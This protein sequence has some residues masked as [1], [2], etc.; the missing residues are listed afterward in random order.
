MSTPYIVNQTP[1]VMTRS[2]APTYPASDP[3]PIFLARL[4]RADAKPTIRD[5]Q[6]ISG[7]RGQRK[8]VFSYDT[9]GAQ[10]EQQLRK[11]S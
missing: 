8:E 2:G 11:N 5:L 9:R 6:T 3:R 7:V 4:R 10:R 1:I